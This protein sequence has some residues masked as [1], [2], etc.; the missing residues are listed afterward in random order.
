MMTGPF[1]VSKLTDMMPGVPCGADQ[2]MLI[3]EIGLAS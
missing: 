2:S 1:F 3:S